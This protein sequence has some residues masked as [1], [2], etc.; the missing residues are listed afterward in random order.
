MQLNSV[1]PDKGETE[2][3]LVLE[4]TNLGWF[5]CIMFGVRKMVCLKGFG[6]AFLLLFLSF[7]LL[8]F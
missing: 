1:A 8:S 6:I 2:L 3:E 4:Y 5:Y 7:L